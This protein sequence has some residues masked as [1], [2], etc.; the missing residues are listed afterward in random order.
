MQ[1]KTIY[2]CFLLFLLPGALAAASASEI[3][4]ECIQISNKLASVG[5]DECIQRDLQTSDGR[6]VNDIPIL[7]R[8]YPPLPGHRKPLGRVLLIG[9]IHGDEYSSVSVVF[10]WMK[11]LD[12]HHSGKFHWHIVPLLNPDGLL[13]KDSQRMNANGIDLDR[14]FPVPGSDQEAY[15]YWV[16]KTGSDPRLYPGEQLS[17]EPE[18]QWLVKEID[19]FKPDVIVSLHA[20]YDMV[21]YPG[22]ENVPHKIGHLNLNM[23]GTRPGSL[24]RYAGVTRNIPI[25]SIELPFAEIMPT[26][27]QV[28]DIWLDLVKRLDQ[29]LSDTAVTQTDQGGF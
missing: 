21:D 24:A 20:P 1:L 27:N 18:V 23:P 16:D 19:S 28:N 14:N 9:G 17:S 12:L 3:S 22:T 10:K 15:R 26:F 6:S 8:E 5:Y 25:I 11:I 13:Q 4:D 29:Q 2:I 7:T